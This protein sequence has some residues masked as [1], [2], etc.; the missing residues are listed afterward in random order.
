MK[1]EEASLPAKD[2]DCP[3]MGVVAV[4]HEGPVWRVD[5]LEKVAM[6]LSWKGVFGMVTGE[7]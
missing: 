3:V 6:L 5:S 4:G 7:T 1:L 2:V